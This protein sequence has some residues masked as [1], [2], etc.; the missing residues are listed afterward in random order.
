MLFNEVLFDR[1]YGIFFDIVLGKRREDI[2]VINER[3]RGRLESFI[4]AEFVNF[5]VGILAWICC[6]ATFNDLRIFFFSSCSLL[7]IGI[8][9]NFW[10][11]FI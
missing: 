11:I 1:I 2:G 5:W 10:C 4:R 8:I 6:N 7:I 9:R 3:R